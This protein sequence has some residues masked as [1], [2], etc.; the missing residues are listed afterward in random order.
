MATADAIQTQLGDHNVAYI[1]KSTTIDGT[2]DMHYVNGGP[3]YNG[4]ACWCRT[5]SAQTA[6]QQ[7][8]EITTA[9]A[10]AGPV[11]PNLA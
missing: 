1:S 3:G 9:L 2:Y 5:T 7:A 10:T 11:D 6:A 8:T 4:K